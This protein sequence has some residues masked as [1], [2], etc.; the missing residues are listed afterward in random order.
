[1]T[2][3]HTMLLS[4]I[5]KKVSFNYSVIQQRIT[6]VIQGVAFDISG[7]ITIFVRDQSY[8]FLQL[9]DFHTL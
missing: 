4:L 9:R 2:M 7:S 5:G 3:S 8:S 6:G 1:M